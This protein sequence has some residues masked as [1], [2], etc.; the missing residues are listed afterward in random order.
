M[1]RHY[2]KTASLCILGVTAALL[3]AAGVQ[4]SDSSVSA[5]ESAVEAV[6]SGAE[7]AMSG[8]EAVMSDAEAVE[9]P[10]PEYNGADY[11]TLGE[12]AGLAVEAD[13]VTVSPEE[14]EDRVHSEME[15]SDDAQDTLTEGTVEEGDVA[16]IDFTGKKDGTPFDGGSAEGYDLEI[17]SGTFIPGFEEGLIGMA[18]G[19]SKDIDLT[20]PEDY[21]NADL[22]GQDVVFTVTVNSVR[23][24]K[25]LS[26]ELADVL[27]EGEAKTVD[28]F[29]AWIG[30]KIEEEKTE[31]R[32]SSI[33][34]QL[35]SM[36]SGNAS[37]TE[38]PQDL[39][40][41]VTNDVTN[42]FKMYASMYGMD[43]GSFISMAAGTTEEE[44]PAYAENMAKLSIDEEFCV[45]GIAEMENLIPEGEELEKA[46]DELAA[47]YGFAS[48]KDMIEQ[49]GEDAVKYRLAY[50]AVLDYLYDHAVITERQPE[51]DSDVSSLAEEVVEIESVAEEAAVE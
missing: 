41:Y 28:D 7:A 17:G 2:G 21:G 14:V 15:Y 27:S 33:K 36:A 12:Y 30:K 44:F 20:F 16:N 10:R 6:M 3:A 26:D 47:E 38:Y 1:I 46:Y 19:E 22:A 50:N 31:E 4:A 43:F 48:G 24:M 39:L 35:L 18:I 45:D 9:V 23:R 11:V 49:S 32:E 40:E 5:A 37:V 8:A 29:K 13:P 51:A 34:Q 42:Y 25:E